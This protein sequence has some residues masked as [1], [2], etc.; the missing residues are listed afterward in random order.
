MEVRDSAGV[1]LV[2]LDPAAIA[3]R[4]AWEVDDAPVLRLGGAQ[5]TGPEQFHRLAAALRTDH[6]VVVADGGSGEIRWFDSTGAHVRTAGGTGEGPGEFLQLSWIGRGPDGSI[7]AWDRRLRRLS[8]FSDGEFLGDSRPPLPDDRPFPVTH[9]VLP[10]GTVIASPGPVYIPEAEPGAQRP[11]MPVWLF[12]VDEAALDTVGVF[13]GRAVDLRPARNRGWIR[14]EVP[15]GPTT[16]VAVAG[17][18]VVI[19]DNATWELRYFAPNGAL[20]RVV[21]SPM[22]PRLVTEADLRRELD[23]RLEGL[24]PVEEIRAGI[25]ASFEQTRP[26]ER[27]PAFDEI[28]GD[29][30]GLVWV[31]AGSERDPK[32]AWR[33]VDADGAV[34]GTVTTPPGLRI[35]DVGPDYVLGIWRDQLEVEYVQMHRLVRTR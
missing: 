25:R 29:R 1:R 28:L 35:T 10:D 14:T 4:A 33:V 22:E 19:G 16:L 9:G 8:R 12:S 30:E 21:R 6:G 24:P 5:G 32:P 7:L 18:E 23:R 15:Y 17:D 31:R 3:G 34:A 26:A 11:P 20:V 2:D 27:M 13:P